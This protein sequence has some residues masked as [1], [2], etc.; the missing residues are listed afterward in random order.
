MEALRQ[1]SEDAARSLDYAHVAL[2]RQ[3]SDRGIRKIELDVFADPNGGLYAR[4]LGPR[5]A[6][7][8]DSDKDLE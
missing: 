5:I 1:K 6:E 3:F 7:E 4:P 2:A 8:L